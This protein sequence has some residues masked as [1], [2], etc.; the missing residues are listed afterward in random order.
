MLSLLS[1][2]NGFGDRAVIARA[3]RIELHR[4]AVRVDHNE[5]SE[6]GAGVRDLRQFIEESALE[7][8][9]AISPQIRDLERE[10]IGPLPFRQCLAVFEELDREGSVRHARERETV[11]I[12]L[13]EAEQ[14]AAQDVDIE[15]HRTLQV[16]HRQAEMPNVN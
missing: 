3:P 13:G 7:Q 9:R 5:S 15:S 11:A 1:A 10:M 6:P 4:N 12:R 14:L 2:S 8:P 16:L